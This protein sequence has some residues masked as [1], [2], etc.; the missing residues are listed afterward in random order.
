MTPAPLERQHTVADIVALASLLAAYCYA[1]GWVFYNWLFGSLWLEPEA[2][3]VTFDYLAV[4]AA[5]VLG[6]VGTVI[7]LLMSVT[8]TPRK[9]LEKTPGHQ[10]RLDLAIAGS[11]LMISTLAGLAFYTLLRVRYTGA[12]R[13]L[14][15]GSALAASLLLTGVCTLLFVVATWKRGK[16]RRMSVRHFVG[17]L[18]ILGAIVLILAAGAGAQLGST[19][20]DGSPVDSFVLSVRRVYS[21]IGQESWVTATWHLPLTAWCSKWELRFI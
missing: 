2:V 16:G 4:R 9:L 21:S 15:I 18:L 8:G 12:E 6:S 13:I 19:I 11:F 5:V 14:L 10:R 3:G 20:R 17:S 1:T 7:A